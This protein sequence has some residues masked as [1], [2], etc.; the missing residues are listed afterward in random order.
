MK[1]DLRALTQGMGK[2][3]EGG[4]AILVAILMVALCGFVA[5]VVDAGTL[6]VQRTQ[7]QQAVDAAALAGAQDILAPGGNSPNKALAYAQLNGLTAARSLPITPILLCQPM[8][9]GRLEQSE[10]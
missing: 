8:T 9:L 6:F 7:L 1:P 2:S 10:R 5:L 4:V 3:E